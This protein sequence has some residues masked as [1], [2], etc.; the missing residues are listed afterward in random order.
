MMRKVNS[1]YLIYAIEK[2]SVIL[3]LHDNYDFL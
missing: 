1:S 2:K 3:S